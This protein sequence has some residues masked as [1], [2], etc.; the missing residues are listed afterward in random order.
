LKNK[1][2]KLQKEL[3]SLEEFKNDFSD[4]IADFDLEMDNLANQA[5]F[6]NG[7]KTEY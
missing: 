4:F 3:T 6:E 7:Y 2:I 5:K 1:Q